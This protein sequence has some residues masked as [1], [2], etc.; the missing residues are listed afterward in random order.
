MLASLY[1]VFQSFPTHIR[2]LL[3]KVNLSSKQKLDLMNNRLL[4][5]NQENCKK[6]TF[7]YDKKNLFCL[8]IRQ[9]IYYG[10]C[11]ELQSNKP[12]NSKSQK[13]IRKSKPTLKENLTLRYNIQR[14]DV[15]SF[16]LLNLGGFKSYLFYYKKSKQVF[17]V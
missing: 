3:L 7:R 6:C 2:S 17:Y 15:N 16:K 11:N 13:S 10:L 5:K 1:T 4:K 12:S 9:T 8:K 14:F